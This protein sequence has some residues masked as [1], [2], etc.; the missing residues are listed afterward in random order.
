VDIAVAWI[1]AD[2]AR[3]HLRYI[4]AQLVH[5]GTTTCSDPPCRAAGWLAKIVSITSIP[6][7][8]M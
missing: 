3:E 6:T 2:R 7:D 1:G 4:G 8:A 5:A